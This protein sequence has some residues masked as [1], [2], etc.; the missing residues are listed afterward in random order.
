MGLPEI[1]DGVDHPRRHLRHLLPHSNVA[2]SLFR[3]SNFRSSLTQ[4]RPRNFQHGRERLYSGSLAQT[5]IP[6]PISHLTFACNFERSLRVYFRSRSRENF[7][8]L[9]K[10]FCY[11]STAKRSVSISVN[12]IIDCLVYLGF[13]SR[14]CRSPTRFCLKA[15]RDKVSAFAHGKYTAIFSQSVG[16]TSAISIS[17]FECFTVGRGRGLSRRACDLSVVYHR[18]EKRTR[19][20]AA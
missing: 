15:P 2:T 20:K 3:E 13:A 10:S 7:K 16:D 9:P 1:P 17:F 19:R 6:F 11:K 18:F 8:S 12:G 4:W 5:T 14:F